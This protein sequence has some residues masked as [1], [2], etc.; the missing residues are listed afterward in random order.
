[1]SLVNIGEDAHKGLVI[2]GQQKR[3]LVILVVGETARAEN[4]SLGGY[5]RETNPR[6]K[7]RM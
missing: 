5:G 1:M 7:N 6:L 4:F 2:N 3:T